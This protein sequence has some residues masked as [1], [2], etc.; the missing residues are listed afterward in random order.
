LG[1]GAYPY[2]LLAMS[3]ARFPDVAEKSGHYESF[4]IKACLPGG[5]RAVWIRHT[6]HKRPGE[7]AKGSIWFTFFD[8]SAE[9]PRA[10][11]LT[12]PAAELSAPPAGWRLAGDGR[13]QLGDRARRALGLARGHRLRRPRRHL[14]RRRSSSGQ[15]RPAHLTL[16]RLRHAQ[17]R[18]RAPPPRRPR[19][20][21]EDHRD[22]DVL[23]L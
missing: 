11:K 8:A 12:V 22:P 15:A 9:G 3:E 6:V 17:A 21:A 19:P 4:Y 14:V 18:R 7:E 16:D 10:T 1:F 20:H 2:R 5:G 13:P 23:R